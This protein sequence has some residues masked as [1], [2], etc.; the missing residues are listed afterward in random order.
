[1]AQ[2]VKNPPAVQETWVWSL[3]WEDPLEKGKASHSSMLVWR[4]PWTLQPMGSQRVGHNWATFSSVHFIH[5]LCIKI[6]F[7]IVSLKTIWQ[8]IKE[9]ICLKIWKATIILPGHSG[10]GL[11]AQSLGCVTFCDPNCQVPLSM[12]F[13]RQEFWSELPFR[14]AG[15]LP[16]PGI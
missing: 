15:D 3:G 7:Y 13:S 8:I 2:L 1:M 12:E 6:F 4:T 14:T 5:C 11:S 9:V 10:I 16:N